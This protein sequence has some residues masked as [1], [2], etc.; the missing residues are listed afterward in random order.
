[1]ITFL[2]DRDYSR[3]EKAEILDLLFFLMQM[4][5]VIMDIHQQNEF[6]IQVHGTHHHISF[7]CANGKSLIH[8]L[9]DL[10]VTIH[11]S[12]IDKINITT[13][14]RLRSQNIKEFDFITQKT[15]FKFSSIVSEESLNNYIQAIES[16]REDLELKEID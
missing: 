1:M 12:N 4:P 13:H 8:Y 6:I 11:D 3:T 16:F 2:K 14:E 15:D 10:I 5:L 7:T 9:K